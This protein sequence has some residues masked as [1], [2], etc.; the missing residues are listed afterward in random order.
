MS[1]QVQFLVTGLSVEKLLNEARKQGIAFSRV[2]REKNR[3][4]LLR[5][6]P[7]DYEAFSALA[8]EKGFE[9]SPAQP[10]GFMRVEKSMAK[11]VGLLA[12]ALIAIGLLIW[13]LGY[14]WE[15]RIENAGAYLGEV[16]LFLEEQGVRPGIRR[17]SVSL[18][19][20]RENLEWRLPKVK[21]VRAEWEGVSLVVRLEEG[22]PPPETASNEG[23]GDVVAAADGLIQRIT[24]YA[25]TPQVKAGDFVKAGQTLIL[26]EERGKDGSVHPV[27]ARGEVIARQWLS[28]RARVP[29]TEY[30][31]D[32][33]GRETTRMVLQTPWF[34]WTGEDTPDYLTSDFSLETVPVGGAWLPVWL[35]RET[36]AEVSLRKQSRDLTEVKR[37]GA[38]MAIF[39]LN[40]ATIHDETVDKWINFSMIEEDTITVTATAEILKDIGRRQQ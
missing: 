13:A 10:V 11:R 30:L 20:L 24:T 5:C 37:E 12:G 8:R 32:A 27:K 1:G 29:T 36:Y 35:R 40:Q 22:V 31:S 15:V 21:W 2:K 9:V 6:S 19:T 28:V 23:S 33:T 39:A 25:G 3:S 14:V 4:V 34:S 16:R 26:G 17:S 38:E 7:K 18:P